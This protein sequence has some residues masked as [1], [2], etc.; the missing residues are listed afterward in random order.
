MN[1]FF[2]ELLRYEEELRRK[3]AEAARVIEEAR[4]AFAPTTVVYVDAPD[5]VRRPSRK[6]KTRADQRPDGFL[7][8]PVW[9][10]WVLAYHTILGFFV[11]AAVWLTTAAIALV[12]LLV[13]RRLGLEILAALPLILGVFATKGVLPQIRQSFLTDLDR[14]PW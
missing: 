8:F 1:D 6:L 10:L 11:L 2:A 3:D 7:L 13:C 5:E 12:V 9:F 14:Y 4:A